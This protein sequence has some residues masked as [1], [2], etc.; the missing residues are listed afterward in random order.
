MMKHIATAALFFS[1]A[2]GCAT[3]PN[4]G[5]TATTELTSAP[6]DSRVVALMD[7]IECRVE[8]EQREPVEGI[9]FYQ[10]RKLVNH[11]YNCY[12]DRAKYDVVSARGNWRMVYGISPTSLKDLSSGWFETAVNTLK[13]RDRTDTHW[14]VGGT[15]AFR[16]DPNHRNVSPEGI[17]I[18]YS[19]AAI[20]SLEIELSSGDVIVIDE[21][22]TSDLVAQ[23]TISHGTIFHECIT[24]DHCNHPSVCE[25]KDCDAGLV[26]QV[27]GGNVD[28]N[29]FQ[30]DDVRYGECVPGQP[31]GSRT[32]VCGDGVIQDGESCDDGNRE[33]GDGCSSAC[34]NECDPDG[35]NGFEP[36]GAVAAWFGKLNVFKPY[37][38]E[39]T[40]DYDGSKGALDI[41]VPNAG[42]C[43]D[44][45]GDSADMT[46]TPVP[47]SDVLKPF[48]TAGW[49]QETP[50]KG[51]DQYLCCAPASFV[52]GVPPA[53]GSSPGDS[54]QAP[55]G[56]SSSN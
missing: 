51:N 36:V 23:S 15:S 11:H 47:V 19:R 35:T 24:D 21:N 45:W 5:I 48:Y 49:G 18:V 6:V 41:D 13:R 1:T 34:V 50:S 7:G 38:G 3:E 30:T 20:I 14:V 10:P 17:A 55:G 39:W 26:C 54:Q 52:P 53:G 43:Q 27:Y 46:M 4:T 42:Y 56:G 33:S 40:R 2:V 25:V 8:T 44:V 16:P 29:F 22:T 12:L 37:G 32:A 9:D 28:P 31:R